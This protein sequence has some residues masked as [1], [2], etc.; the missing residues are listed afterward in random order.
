MDIDPY[1]LEGTNSDGTPYA[2]FR[3]MKFVGAGGM[4]AVYSAL[5]RRQGRTVAIKLLKPDIVAKFPE[6]KDLFSREVITASSL[7][8]PNIVKVLNWGTLIQGIPFIVMEW[9]EGRTLDQAL[10]SPLP[11]SKVIL[12]FEQIC[13][14]I[15]YAHK[16]KIIHLDLKPENIF[17]IQDKQVDEEVVKVIDFGLSRILSTYSGTTVTRFGGSLHYCS[18]EHFGGRVSPRSDIFSLGI[19]LYQ[20]LTGVLP[21]GG[22]YIMAKQAGRPLPELPPLTRQNPNVPPALEQVIEKATQ[23][24]ADNR[25]QTVEELLEDVRSTFTSLDR[26]EIDKNIASSNIT[27]WSEK[28]AV[29]NMLVQA[30]VREFPDAQFHHL[31]VHRLA[32]AQSLDI[33][34]LIDDPKFRPDTTIIICCF[35]PLEAYLASKMITTFIDSEKSSLHFIIGWYYSGNECFYPMSNVISKTT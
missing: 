3:L 26:S 25:Y 24:R 18:P 30:L 7:N 33:P 15:A 11:L 19:I 10:T 32:S 35:N 2:D 28:A 20:M 9:L 16:K 12:L 22:S 4:G 21:I 14:A 8:H 13:S 34:S 23:Q 31:L 27:K 17:L 1:R 29:Y 6:Y 5:D